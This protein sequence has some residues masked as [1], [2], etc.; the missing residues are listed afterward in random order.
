LSTGIRNSS[1]IGSLG[2][3]VMVFLSPFSVWMMEASAAITRWMA[4][5]TS[6]RV[7]VMTM[8]A[9][10]PIS[11]RFWLSRSWIMASSALWIWI[12]C[13]SMALTRSQ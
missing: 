7:W 1:Q 4:W 9:R 10:V 6:A 12:R 11:T 2:S 5:A 8:G 13:C 3:S